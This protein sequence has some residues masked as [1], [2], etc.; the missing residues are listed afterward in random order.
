[1]EILISIAQDTEKIK[2][3]QKFKSTYNRS[4]PS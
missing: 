2:Y 3:E 4:Y 1:M